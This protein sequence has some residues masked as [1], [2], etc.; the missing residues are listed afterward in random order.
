MVPVM[1]SFLEQS[2]RNVTGIDVPRTLYYVLALI[3]PYSNF[4]FQL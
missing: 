2:Q 4:S 1:G 3:D